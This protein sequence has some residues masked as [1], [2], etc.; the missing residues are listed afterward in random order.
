M[1]ERARQSILALIALTFLGDGV[2]TAQTNPASA[3]A[4]PAQQPSPPP[5]EEQSA[6]EQ[7]HLPSWEVVGETVTVVGRETLR[8]E[9][10]IGDYRQPRWT[11]RRRFGE[12]RVYV[13]PSGDFEFEYWLVPKLE[14]HGEPRQI[15]SQYEV[16]LGLPHHLQVDLYLVTNKV[17][18]SGSLDT[19]EAKL[20]VR[21]AL[22]DWGRLWGNPTLYLE[23]VQVSG[24]PDHAEGKLLLGDQLRPRLHWGANLVFEHEMGGEGTNAYELTLGSSYTVRDEVFSLGAEAKLA[25]E[26]T[27]ADR[28]QFSRETLLGPSLQYRPLPQMHVDFAA[29]AGI[30]G[31]SP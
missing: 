3:V 27:A 21:H 16:E 14:R 7:R 5:Q 11:A 25:W 20:E 10:L 13:I 31:D 1:T 28:G 2:S 24:A 19:E 12:T 30:G 17:G 29:L 23:W 22:A 26:D 9:E 15:Q 8:D 4:Q 18:G 6:A